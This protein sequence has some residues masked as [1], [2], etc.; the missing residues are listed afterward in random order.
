MV[1]VSSCRE[2]LQWFNDSVITPI[3][4]FFTP[5]I[6]WFKDIF[7]KAWN[8]IKEIWS[9]VTGFFSSIWNGIKTVFSVV[10]TWFKNIFTTAWTGIKNVFAPVGTFFSGIWNGIKSAFG[11]VTSWFKETFSKAWTAVKNVFSTGGKIFDG[12]KDG[13]SSVFKTVVNAII[14]GINKVI[15]VPFNAINGLLNKIRKVSVVGIEPFKSFI[16]HNALSVPQIP[17]LATGTNKVEKEGIA[18]LHKD[19]AV[20]PK[21]Y[22]PAI[23]NDVMKDTVMDALTNFTNTKVQNASNQNG[24]SELTRLIKQYMPMIIE[25]MGQEIV[26]DDRT[27]VGKIAPRIDKELGV[28][29]TNKSRG[30]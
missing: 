23:N 16:K 27:L 24:I 1:V 6:Q 26:L 29:A 28:I 19:E 30:Y 5:I 11:S 9:K 14:G 3:I 21:K 2:M 25:N 7:T 4:N 22:N 18:Y 15:A 20:V 17:K 8:G 13:I 12:I 10:G